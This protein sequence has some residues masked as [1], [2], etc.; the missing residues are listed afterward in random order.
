MPSHDLDA[1]STADPATAPKA[2]EP[3][4]ANQPTSQESQI[5]SLHQQLQ[6]ALQEIGSLRQRALAESQSQAS[7]SGLEAE[8]GPTGTLWPFRQDR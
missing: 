4:A 6:S 8:S 1:L 2:T 7:L 3:Q 5:R